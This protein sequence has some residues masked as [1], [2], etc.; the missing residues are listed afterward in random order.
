MINTEFIKSSHPD[1]DKVKQIRTEVFTHEQGA[2][3][4]EEFDGFDSDEKT[5][6]ALIYK[7]GEPSATGRIAELSEGCCKIGRIAVKK[8]QRGYGLGKVLVESLVKKCYDLGYKTVKVDSQLHAVEFYKKFGFT[9]TGEKTI[10]DR[11]IE[12]LPMQMTED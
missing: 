2:N 7:G 6:Y 4:G 12:H 11:G 3:D 10:T 5:L 9:P 8:S 1:F